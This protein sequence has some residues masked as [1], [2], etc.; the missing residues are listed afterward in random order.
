VLGV[1]PA[2]GAPLLRGGLRLRAAHRQAAPAARRVGRRYSGAP[3]GG[4]SLRLPRRLRG[5]LADLGRGL[6]APDGLASRRRGPPPQAR[7][8]PPAPRAP[9]PGAAGRA[10]PRPAPPD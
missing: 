7:R 8:R 10:P 3:R 1:R 2:R 6:A 9:D 5:P 4:E